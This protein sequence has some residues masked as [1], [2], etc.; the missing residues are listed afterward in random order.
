MNQRT[1]GVMFTLAS[2]LLAACSS[3]PVTPTAAAPAPAAAA[4]AA[5]APT[6]TAKPAPASTV[7][8][9]N[10]P[11]H[12]DPNNAISKERSV[13]FDFD[14]FSIKAEFSALIERHGKYLAGSPAL[15]IKVEG[16]ADERGSTEYN[17]ALGQKR[18]EAVLRSLK[19]YGAKDQQM[20]AVS[21][22]EERPVASG[23]DEAAWAKNRRADLVYP[24][25]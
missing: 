16:N 14:D 3:T 18:A 19:I 13:Y 6:A 7:A 9:V 5:P 21:W 11:A 17:L 1:L 23:H 22:G 10:L 2:A 24:K 15:A 25:Q 4:P 20:E 12:L 8:T